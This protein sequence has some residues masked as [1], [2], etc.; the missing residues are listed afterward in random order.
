M[1]TSSDWG[2]NLSDILVLCAFGLAQPLFN[3][4]SKNP[5]FF[6]AHQ[7]TALE[8]CLMAI[9]LSVLPACLLVTLEALVSMMARRVTRMVHCAVLAFLST[10]TLLPAS[11]WISGMSGGSRIALVFAVSAALSFGYLKVRS[12]RFSLLFLLPAVAFFPLLFLF[13]SPVSKLVWEKNT[14]LLPSHRIANPV[15]IVMVIFDEFPLSSLLNEQNLIDELH[16]P[17]FASLAKESTWYRNATSVCDGTLHAVPAILD[18]QFPQPDAGLLPNA[19][20]HPHNLFTLLAGSYELNVHESNTRLCP[21]ELCQDKDSISKNRQLGVLL[22]DLSLVYLY[23]V[24]PAEMTSGL[25]SI[26]NS[27][28]NFLELKADHERPQPTVDDYHQLMEWTGRAAGFRQFVDSICLSNKP[29]LHFLHILLPHAPWQFLPSGKQFTFDDK[30]RGVQGSNGSGID[31]D[32]WGLDPWPVTLAYQQHLLQV[33]FVD[34]LVGDLVQHLKEVGLYDSALVVIVADHGSSFRPGLSRRKPSPGN[35]A[36]I[37]SVP[38]FVK[39]PHQTHGKIDDRN[40]ETVD[41]LPTL[42][43]LLKTRM[44]WPT[45]GQ[46]FAGPSGKPGKHFV[47]TSNE[48]IDLKADDFAKIDKVENKIA[49]FGS[50]QAPDW[51]YRVGPNHEIVGLPLNHFSLIKNTSL[52]CDIERLNHYSNINS[53]NPFLLAKLKGQILRPEKKASAPTPLA[54]AVNGVIRAVTMSFTEGD[55]E[56]FAVLL[57]ESAFRQGHNEVR[58]FTAFSSGGISLQELVKKNSPN[59]SWGALVD[60]TSKGNGLQFQGLGWSRA[61]KTHTWTV[62]RQAHLI[63]KLPATNSP[64]RLKAQFLPYLVPG[65]I[66]TQKMRIFANQNLIKEFEASDPGVQELNLELPAGSLTG[67]EMSV[68]TFEFPTA[69]PPANIDESPDVRP[70]GI[71]LIWLTMTPVVPS[72]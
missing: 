40:V 52:K 54:V 55:K 25:P 12:S 1:K 27:Y 36:D 6:V 10:L 11:K 22:S 41:L 24:L 7:T 46:S 47:I 32:L 68:I 71:A 31:P 18:G 48:V 26:S 43:D 69:I 72:S 70:L 59:Y 20:D 53:N 51:P 45:D 37:L 50:V 56:N 17:H 60:F 57:P 2:L 5:G 49:Q 16:Y 42:A 58:V 63:F 19:A 64:I 30:I 33:G 65:K 38:L 23:R 21:A 15:P 9:G 66:A 35:Y 67:S 61:E 34:R 3:L 29:T 13:H 39:L 14:G 44:G 4:L 28:K 62:A 8:I